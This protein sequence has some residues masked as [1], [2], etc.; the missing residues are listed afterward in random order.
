MLNASWSLVE[1]CWA[2]ALHSFLE[3]ASYVLV[4]LTGSRLFLGSNRFSFN[5]EICYNVGGNSVLEL[6]NTG[7]GHATVNIRDNSSVNANLLQ[8]TWVVLTMLLTEHILQNQPIY[9]TASAQH[10]NW[11]NSSPNLLRYRIST[12]HL[13]DCSA[14]DCWMEWFVFFRLLQLFVLLFKQWK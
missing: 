10:P 9:H 1:V 3:C 12:L 14:M 8:L 7:R 11:A 2:N 13:S 5:S 4:W 6:K